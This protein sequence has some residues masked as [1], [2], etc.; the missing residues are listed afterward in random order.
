[1]VARSQALYKPTMADS[2]KTGVPLDSLVLGRKLYVNHCGSCH[3]LFLP[4]K[5]TE[6]KWSDVMPE[7]QKKAKCNSLEAV[8]IMSYLKVRA[9]QD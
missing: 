5:F 2:Q 9:K 1:M 7:M 8:I 4:A 6:K 3:S